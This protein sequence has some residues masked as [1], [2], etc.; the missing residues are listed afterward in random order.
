MTRS[1]PFLTLVF[2]LFLGLIHAVWLETAHAIPIMRV[3]LDFTG[4]VQNT[5]ARAI[6]DIDLSAPK[7]V[8][9]TGRRDFGITLAQ[10]T[11][12]SDAFGGNTLNAVVT[13][14]TIDN[15]D[16]YFTTYPLRNCRALFKPAPGGLIGVNCDNLPIVNSVF[17][18]FMDI[19]SA[20]IP[21][22]VLPDG[23]LRGDFVPISDLFLTR[24]QILGQPGGTPGGVPEPNVLVLVLAG[25]ISIVL[26]GGGTRTWSTG[27]LG[28]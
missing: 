8:Q 5:T 23:L 21:M 17:G 26:L 6:F 28:H 7:E 12:T 16:I 27:A 15:T 10:L 14:N 19:R 22:S 1:H 9:H 11:A 20:L 18:V 13:P 3:Q 2:S 4:S 25:I 24:F